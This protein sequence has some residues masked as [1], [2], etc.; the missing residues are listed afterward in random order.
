MWAPLVPSYGAVLRAIQFSEAA[1]P[2]ARPQGRHGPFEGPPGG[3]RRPWT[4]LSP[5]RLLFSSISEL[6]FFPPIPT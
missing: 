2:R 6:I 3:R 1:G 5:I 4:S